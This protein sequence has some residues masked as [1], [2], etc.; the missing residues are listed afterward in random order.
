MLHRG[1]VRALTIDHDIDELL[2]QDEAE[3]RAK[4]KRLKAFGTSIDDLRRT[5]AAAASLAEELVTTGDLS[6]AELTRVFKLSKVERAALVPS[7]RGSGA[8]AP[9]EGADAAARPDA[10]LDDAHHNEGEHVTH[11]ADHNL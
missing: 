2:R 7:R 10:E 11:G 6:R 8:E 4:R 5:Q 3:L 1:K 9:V